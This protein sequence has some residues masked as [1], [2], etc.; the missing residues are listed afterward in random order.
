M[1]VPRSRAL[2]N[3]EHG[4]CAYR[5]TNA[6]TLRERFALTLDGTLAEEEQIATWV[7]QPKRV[8]WAKPGE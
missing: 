1:S 5:G 7:V 6:T 3:D 4:V 8:L 2:I